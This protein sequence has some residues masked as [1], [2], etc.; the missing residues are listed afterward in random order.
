M[1]GS[2]ALTFYAADLVRDSNGQIN[3]LSDLTQAPSGAGYALENRLV[4]SRVLPSLFRDSHTHRLA[5]FFRTVRHAL[6]R[7]TPREGDEPNIVL[8]SPGPANEAYFEHAYLANYL[9]Y[10]LVEGGDLTVRDNRVWLITLEGLRP[11][12]GFNLA[13]ILGRLQLGCGHVRRELHDLDR[14]AVLV[15]DRIIRS[16]QPDFRA[17]LCQPLDRGQRACLANRG[18]KACAKHPTS[19]RRAHGDRSPDRF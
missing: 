15:K 14:L 13:F 11:V 16:P 8:L 4:I 9:G 1:P 6:N 12:D 7:L 19:S 10:T 18:P 5:N 17:A 3:V 2:R